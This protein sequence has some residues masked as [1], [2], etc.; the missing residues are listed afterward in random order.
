TP[1]L[2]A[3]GVVAN[4][5]AARAA[6]VAA[7]LGLVACMIIPAVPW[8]G[9]LVAQ[10][11]WLPSAWIAAVST[12]FSGLPWASLPWLEGGWGVL[13]ALVIGTLMLLVLFLPAQKRLRVAAFACLLLVVSG[14]VGTVGGEQLRRRLSPPPDWVVAACDVGQG[15]AVL[16]RNAGYVALVDTGPEPAVLDECL[17][18]L[19]VSRIDLLV[20]THFDLDHVGGVDAVTGRVGQA[21]VGPSAGSDDDRIVQRLADAGSAVTQVSRGDTGSLGEL[22]WQVLWPPRQPAG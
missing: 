9:T 16:V 3:Y 12:F 7:V 8:L 11:A 19:G 6:P 10:M 14:Y 22:E 17:S 20:L 21:L 15:D 2:P 5:L 18:T 4:I 1:T 13:V